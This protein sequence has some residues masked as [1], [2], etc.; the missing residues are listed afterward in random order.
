MRRKHKAHEEDE[1]PT[2]LITVDKILKFALDKYVE[3]S[4]INN[5]V[6]GPLSKREAEFVDLAA[7]VT[8]LKGNLKLAEKIAKK[9]KQNRGGGGAAPKA[10]TGD[11]RNPQ[12][13]KAACLDLWQS[14]CIAL[15]KVPPTP[16]GK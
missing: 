14:E 3:Q 12:K 10:R 1:I 11:K 5:H 7:K 2:P 8:T 13:E 6:W 15:K 9:Q 16:G 4:R